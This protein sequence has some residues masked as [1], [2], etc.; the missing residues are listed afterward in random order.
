MLSQ[1]PPTLRQLAGL[2]A[3]PGPLR[4]SVV[5]VIDAQQE[6]VSGALPLAGVGDALSELARLLARARAEACPVLHIVHRGSAGGRAF[7]PGSAGFEIAPEAAPRP[8]EV[9]LEKRLPNAFTQTGLAET[10]DRLG[11]KD[12]VVAGFMT[13]MCVSST[14]RAAAEAG[15]R[16]A[17]VAAACATRD[18]PDPAG[19]ILPAAV[20]HAAHLAALADRFAIVLPNTASLP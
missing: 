5:L 12:L 16:C 15:Y 1:P 4:E 8:G 10:L 7:A 20:V 3:L 9:I 13:H 19:G 11:R 17:V 14:V 18:L 2:A 6:Y